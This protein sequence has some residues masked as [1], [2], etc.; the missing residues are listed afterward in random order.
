MTFSRKLSETIKHGKEF[1]I[2]N[3]WVEV[4]QRMELDKSWGTERVIFDETFVNVFERFSVSVQNEAN[5]Q[6]RAHSNGI[7]YKKIF[8]YSKTF[9]RKNGE[10]TNFFNSSLFHF[11]FVNFV[12]GFVMNEFKVQLFYNSDIFQK[13]QISFLF[14]ELC[15]EDFNSILAWYF[16]KTH[17]CI[18]SAKH[19][20]KKSIKCFS[21][22]TEPNTMF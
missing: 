2:V 22:L 19:Q 3:I 15:F 13:N 14:E 17:W 7:F 11:F 9:F 4:E 6:E 1:F 20:L 12:E 21:N 10:I 18:W 16:R 8:F 5:P